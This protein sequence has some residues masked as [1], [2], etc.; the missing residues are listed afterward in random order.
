MFSSHQK[1][2]AEWEE[3]RTSM[4]FG[5]EETEAQD[6][7]YKLLKVLYLSLILTVPT[8]ALPTASLHLKLTSESNPQSRRLNA[9]CVEL[10]KVN[11]SKGHSYLFYM[12]LKELFRMPFNKNIL[13]KSI[14]LAF[15]KETL[16]QSWQMQSNN[17]WPELIRKNFR[18]WVSIYH[19]EDFIL[20]SY[21]F[22]SLILNKFKKKQ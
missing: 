22:A 11:L 7:S 5:L 13:K 1:H 2:S 14:F 19:N 17:H 9:F 6:L 18:P 15:P 20:F 12:F 10:N 3:L 8:A 16:S 21:R 4:M